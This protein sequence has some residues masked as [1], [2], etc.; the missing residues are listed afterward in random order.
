MFAHEHSEGLSA[1]SKVIVVGASLAGWRAV[2]TLRS[3]GYMGSILLVGEER[4]LPYDRPPLSKQVLAGTWPPEKAVLADNRRAAE[5][6]IQR[7]W[8]AAPCTSTLRRGSSS[9]TTA[10]CWRV[11]VSC[12][13]PG[14]SLDRCRAPTACCSEMACSR[15]APS[16]TRLPSGAAVTAVDEARVVVIGAGFIG[17]EVAPRART[18]GA[19]SLSSRRSTSLCATSS[20]TW[21]G[22]TSRRC[23][24]PTVWTCAPVSACGASD[25]PAPTRRRRLVVELDGGR[26][27]PAD[28]VV[29]GIGVLPSTG[30]A[31]R[32]RVDHRQRH[33][34]RRRPLRCGRHRGG[35]GHRALAVAARWRGGADPDRALA[36][37]GRGGR[38]GR[39]QPAGRP[40]SCAGLHTGPVLLVRSVRHSPPGA[41]EPAWQRR[42]PHCRGTPEEGKFVALFGRAGRL[43]AVMAI[44]RP[45]QLMGFRPLLEA[46]HQ[47]G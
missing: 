31:L 43:R 17:A 14:P 42:D 9:S 19:V 24:R 18:S 10:R 25:A 39:T 30:V 35:R 7:S 33:R 15:C 44:S 1:D 37:R 12:W 13:R 16:T 11:M 29:V 32:I 38:R 8:V 28:V 46:G 41:G 3:E 5:H 34:L 27:F 4:H 36:G 47:L 6:R 40:G 22:P 21:S 2:E 45:R 20:V 26:P 23:T